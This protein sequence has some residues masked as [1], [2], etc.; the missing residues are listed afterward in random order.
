MLYTFSQADY[1]QPELQRILENITAQD[2]VL[3]WQN[4]VLL[5]VKYPEFFADCYILETDVSARNLTALLPEGH[6]VRLIS[7]ENL[8]QLTERFS[9]QFAL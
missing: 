7:M 1:P 9:P 4:G 8:V 6:K 5:A 3:L 2:A